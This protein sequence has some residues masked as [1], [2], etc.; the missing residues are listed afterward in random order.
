MTVPNTS[1]SSDTLG[2]LV[3]AAELVDK[4][5]GGSSSLADDAGHRGGVVAVASHPVHRSGGLKQDLR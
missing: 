5:R 4:V 3:C 1:A 2:G